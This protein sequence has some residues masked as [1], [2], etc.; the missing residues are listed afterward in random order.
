MAKIYARQGK[1]AQLLDIWQAPPAHLQPIMEK[2]ALDVSLLTVDIL[3]SAKNYEL[4]ERHVLDLIERAILA[5]GEGNYDPLR[6]LCSARVNIWTSL[7]DASK[8]LY[9]SAE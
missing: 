9:P 6:Q 8:E 4:L 3:A 2:H 1:H 5:M 7:I